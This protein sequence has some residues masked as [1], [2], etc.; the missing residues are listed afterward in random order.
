MF[1]FTRKKSCKHVPH[2]SQKGDEKRKKDDIKKNEKKNFMR[3]DDV[4]FLI[5]AP[6]TFR[7]TGSDGGVLWRWSFLSGK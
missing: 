2:K 1:L 7:P 5:L 6:T 3:S 4:S